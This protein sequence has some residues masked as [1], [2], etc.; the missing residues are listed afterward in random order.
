MDEWHEIVGFNAADLDER[1]NIVNA[2]RIC[3]KPNS[4]AESAK[5]L[6]AS[7]T[8]DFVSFHVATFCSVHANPLYEVLL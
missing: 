7:T 3:F 6:S 8:F 4:R 2:S 5:I 1:H